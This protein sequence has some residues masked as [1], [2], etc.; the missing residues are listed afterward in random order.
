MASTPP[1]F[2]PTG[3]PPTYEPPPP[4]PPMP[5]TSAPAE[6][7]PLPFEQENM[8]FLEGLYETAKLIV[9]S[10]VEAF[11]RVRAG[12]DLG[13]PLLYA[14]IFGW[15]GIIASQIYEIALRGALWKMLP[16]FGGAQEQFFSTGVSVAMMV[17]APIIVLLGVFVASLIFH[18]FLLL[19]GGAGGGLATTVKV[20]CYTSTVQITQVVPLCGGIIGGLWALV[21]Y[22]VGLAAAHRT[23]YG[24]AALA[25]LLPMVLCCVCIAVA[26]AFFG[27][28]IWAAIAGS[29]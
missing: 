3:G 13:R 8:P 28:A 27:A 18:L 5:P 2:D 11:G 24:K 12:G 1:P 20:V 26:V 10:P 17:I 15:I 4:P 29:R 21:L 9:T 19:V 16:G 6:E 7:F 23:S 22:I 25:V 14:V